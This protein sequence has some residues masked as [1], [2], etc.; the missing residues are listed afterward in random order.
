MDPAY[1]VLVFIFSGAPAAEGLHAELH[2]YRTYAFIFVW[3]SSS[4]VN[5][6]RA[7]TY[8]DVVAQHGA[9]T[10]Q[11]IAYIYI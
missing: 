8:N 5:G 4:V 11:L 9:H 3:S 10:N 1:N 7:C 6:L 2:T